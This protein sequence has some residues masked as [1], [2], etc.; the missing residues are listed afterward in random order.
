MSFLSGPSIEPAPPV[1]PEPG[2]LDERAAAEEA[3]RARR[4]LEAARRGVSSLR[5]E[6][7]SPTTST[8]MRGF[9]F[10]ATGLQIPT[11]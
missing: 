1:P 11:S 2:P 8:G 6:P 9:N 10:G 7:A 5:I 3:I 4:R